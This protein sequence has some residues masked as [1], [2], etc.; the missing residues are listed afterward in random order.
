MDRHLGDGYDYFSLLRPLTELRIVKA[1]AT[2]PEYFEAV[3]SCNRNFKQSGPAARRFCLACPK[4]VFVALMARPWLSDRD[5]HRWF[6]G[7]PLADPANVTLVEELLGVT[8]AKPFECVGTPDETAAA[9]HL[10][11]TRG[12]LLPHGV[13]TAFAAAC[14]AS[15][16]DL[17]SL[18]GLALSRSDEHELSRERVAQL[19]DYLAR[20]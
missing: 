2:H 19:D 11:R 10:A 7:D 8:G 5:Y 3:T 6:G 1:F 18:A 13:M 14:T 20:H 4:C 16:F 9:I 17:E 15:G 12:H